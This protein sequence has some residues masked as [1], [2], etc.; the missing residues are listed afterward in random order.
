MQLLD[1]NSFRKRL[2]EPLPGMP[3]QMAMMPRL[4]DKSR[5]DLSRKEKAIPGGVLI[6]MYPHEGEIYIPLMLRPEY[7]GAHSGQV[8][9]PGGR[10]EPDDKDLSMTALRESNEELGIPDEKV[11]VL[12]E[13][14]ELFIIASNFS[15]LPVIGYLDQRPDFIPDPREV[16]EVIETPISMLL[17]DD[18]IKE[19][20][21]KVGAGFHIDAPYFDIKGHHV[22][23]ATA[24]MMSEFLTVYKDL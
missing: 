9:F 17:E 3:A 7:G 18:A 8:S 16:V 23:G 6:L 14:T 13:L 5:F 12:G 10:K 22:W 21:F 20:P 2:K 11:E 24:M 1:K 19:R 15:V 4:S